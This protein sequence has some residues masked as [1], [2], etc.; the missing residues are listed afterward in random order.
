MPVTLPPAVIGP[1]LK[2]IF[3]DPDKKL[4][5]YEAKHMLS[6]MGT[7]PVEKEYLV[8]ILKSDEFTI[9]PDVRRLMEDTLGVSPPPPSGVAVHAPGA[10]KAS[11]ADDELYLGADGIIKSDSG[12]N[13]Y[14]RS[15]VK[16]SAGVLRFDHGSPA[17]SSGVLTE[18]ERQALGQ[19]TPGQGLDKAAA[20]FGVEVN[21]FEAMASSKD[22]YDPNAAFWNGQCHAWTWSSLNS[23]VNKK[24][25]VDGPENQRGLWI[26]GEWMSRADLGNWMMA[27]GDV[28][29]NTK[30]ELFL[31]APNATDLLKGV[32]QY[33]MNGGGGVIG[34]VFND[35]KRR[36]YQV[37]N[38]PF[39]EAAMEVK[40]V[41][42]EAA[43]RI[44][45]RA[46]GD[47]VFGATKV[48]LVRITARYGVET[49]DDH[50]GAPAGRNSSWNVYAV[51]DSR[52]KTLTAYMADDERLADIQGLE[53]KFTDDLPDFFRKPIVDP[54]V[55]A[56]LSG[57]PNHAID[58]SKVGKEFR[59]FVS[60]V[61]AKGVPGTVRAAFEEDVKAGVS[62]GALALKYPN[63]ANAYSP[64]QWNREF[65]SKGL[66]PKTFGAAW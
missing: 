36:S 45:D 6:Q 30:D 50:E 65:G 66:E 44:L 2:K 46:H 22:F 43:D 1:Q 61:L 25:D 15:Y 63:V 7:S 17:P 16:Q 31:Q 21:G 28:S 19:T 4:Q 62:P 24:V 38:Q 57:E 18:A 13:P 51:T 55:E 54:V 59:F 58:A 42:D 3:L 34:D 5:L 39:S 37:W 64:E 40:T 52:G 10:D 27:V 47:G 26:A 33:M 48:K 12:V 56:A 53:T 8:A 14:T 20:I 9:E 41:S 29:I 11:L 60:T 23:W 32:T 35:A 49:T